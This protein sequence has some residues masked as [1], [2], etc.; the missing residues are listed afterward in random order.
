MSPVAPAVSD[1]I[2]RT[3]AWVCENYLYMRPDRPL[4]DDTPLLGSGVI[5]S[6]GVIELVSFL[7]DA[8]AFSIADEEIVEHNLGTLASIGRFVHERCAPGRRREGSAVP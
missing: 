2:E 7:Q 3:R 5:D 6:V 4:R 1:V 8:F